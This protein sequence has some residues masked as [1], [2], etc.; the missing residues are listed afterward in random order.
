MGGGVRGVTG[1]S[2]AEPCVTNSSAAVV[3]MFVFWFEI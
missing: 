3:E 1:H 2:T